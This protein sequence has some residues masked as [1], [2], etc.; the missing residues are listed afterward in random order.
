ML[1]LKPRRLP[2][3]L[4]STIHLPQSNFPPRACPPAEFS[5]YL[6]R[7]T[8]DLY[9]WQQQA[10]A[11]NAVFTLHD[12]PPYANGDLHI[13]HA[14][15]KILKDI[16]C[17]VQLLEG[18]RVDYRPGWDCHGLPIE[19]KAIENRKEPAQQGGTEGRGGIRNAIAVRQAARQLAAETVEKQKHT[20][21][22]WAIM[23]DWEHA[24]KT[25]DQSFE[26]SQLQVFREM[27]KQGQIYR[28][29]KPVY[30]SPSTRTA[31]AEAELEYRDDHV[32]TA[33]YVKFSIDE[34]NANLPAGHRKA[35]NLSALIW[36][37]TPWTIPANRAIG[38]NEDLEYA[39]VEDG[40]GERL[41]LAK[42]RIPV[43]ETQVGKKLAM[44]TTL[45]GT[46]LHGL[47]YNDR[48]FDEKSDTRKF[49]PASFVSSESGS[50]LVHLAPGHGA[51][52]YALCAKHSIPAFA[53]VDEDGRFTALASSQ[54]PNILEGKSVFGEG[55]RLVLELLSN[56]G[57]LFLQHPYVHTYPH[58]WRSKQPV[59]LRAT[60]QWFANVGS[61]QDLATQALENVKFVP[62][63]SR[64]RLQ[65][66]VRNRTEWCISRQRAWGV[67]IPALYHRTTGAA[68]LTAESVDHIISVIAERG[69]DAWWN[70]AP[71]DSSWTPPSLR[72]DDGE[73]VYCRGV[74]TMDVW[75]DS[76]SSWTQ[77]A[78]AD[79]SAQ[80][81]LGQTHVA[82]MYLE[83]TD[84]HRGWFQSSLLTRIAFASD[85]GLATSPFRSL[86][87]HGFTLDGRGHKMSKSLGNV[88]SPKEIIDGTLLPP[89]RKKINGQ[90]TEFRDAMG[91]DAL[92]LWVAS[93]DFTKDVSISQPTLKIINNT[94][95]KYRVTFKQLLGLIRD[96]DPLDTHL[97][98]AF[99]MVHRIAD[100]HL[101]RFQTEV[102]RHYRSLEY[103][104]AVLEVNRY[105]NQDLSAFYL[106]CVKDAAYCGVHSERLMVQATSLN[107]FLQLQMMLAPITP[108]LVHETWEHTPDHI[109]RLIHLS[110]GQRQW[111]D[112]W[113]SSQASEKSRRKDQ[114]SMQE[115]AQMTED[116][117]FLMNII[118]TVQRVQ[119]AARSAKRMGSSL[120]C[121]VILQAETDSAHRILSRYRK[122]LETLLVV[123]DLTIADSLLPAI[124]P[125][126][127]WSHQGTAD[128]DG[129][130]TTVHVCAPRMDKCARCYR[131][132]V[133][134][135]DEP[136][137]S[138]CDR[139]EGI[140][141]DLYQQ[142]PDLFE[143]RATK[144]LA[145]L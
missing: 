120:Q 51:D 129:S 57:R 117:P 16:T 15:N 131:Y 97:P 112:K 36:T 103:H 84:Q 116:I 101:G 34:T 144:C 122:D 87:T 63:S 109:R 121:S 94:L 3:S 37:T 12:G 124:V 113:V 114:L 49:I 35:S 110:P 96:F 85:S 38:Y 95:A 9:A 145:K 137:R 45:K 98:L 50:G 93:G 118:A 11:A 83:G 111:S 139:C 78:K 58:D 100:W 67:P 70:D 41:L 23:A 52:D 77:T 91:L 141:E 1:G 90:M 32:S 123:S 102:K 59:I 74:D 136:S 140:L 54:N 27:V 81:Q 46:D 99:G 21:Q 55:N 107:I 18:K 8:N 65:S 48:L 28:Q 22:Q 106:E 108:V 14:L 88:V 115:S 143:L 66:F 126:S 43:V 44:L 119:E 71:F 64:S 20:F 138:L 86:V 82:D 92:R 133:P 56:C 19:L 76:G 69:T 5:K 26:I 128:L 61:L 53:P 132:A 29:R 127:Q 4:K 17:R 30:W 105:V 134:S 73:T 89:L 7:C 80:E 62:E 13:G 25:M 24:W 47:S 2:K 79:P 39:I 31:L 130:R 40:S 72:T 33:A 68:L 6:R 142:R 60:E 125:N 104:K 135:S 42:S 75:F 10:R